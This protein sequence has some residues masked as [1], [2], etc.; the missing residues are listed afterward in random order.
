MLSIA[1]VSFDGKTTQ[2]QFESYAPKAGKAYRQQEEPNVS[3]ANG[4]ISLGNLVTN[5]DQTGTVHHF[6]LVATVGI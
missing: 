5:L 4:M 1:L 3:D 2:R 6:I